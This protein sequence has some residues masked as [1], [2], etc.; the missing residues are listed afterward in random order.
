A[1]GGM[2]EVYLAEDVKLRRRVA[3]KILPEDMFADKSRLLRFEREADVVSALNHPNILTIFEF[4]WE[5]NI[6]L[7]ASEF[8][9]GETLRSRIGSSNLRLPETLDIAIQIASALHAAHQA[10]VVHRDI[11]PEN[12]MIRDDGYVKVLDFGLA[13]LTEGITSGSDDETR[14]ILSR[15]GV[16]MGTVTYMSPEQTRAK[17]IDAR[18]DLFSLGVVL[19]EMLAG[20]VPFKGETTTDV[21]AEIIQKNP[22]PVRRFM[23]DDAPAEL[24][25]IIGKTLEKN[26]E[27]RYQ[28]AADLLIDLKHLQKKLEITANIEAAATNVETINNHVTEASIDRP[29]TRGAAFTGTARKPWYAL[30]ALVALM[31]AAV[32]ALG[33]WYYNGLNP[34]QIDS[35]A[36]MPFVNESGNSD[37]EYLSDGM[38]ETLISS[39]SQL[40]NLNVK[41]RSSVFRY[42]GKDTDAQIIGKE[43]NVQAI[44]KGRVLQRGRDL[45]LYVEL[46]E[47]ATENS[48]WKQT[49]NKTLTNLVSL[50]SEIAQ[51]VADKLKVKLSG[52]DEQKL[53]KNYTENAEA[54]Q[55]YLKGRYHL[56][57][58]TRKEIE[59][60]G[61]Y[62]QQA[63]AIDPSYALAYA[64]LADANRTLAMAGERPPK[65]FMP[66]A[67]AAAAKAIE[68]DETLA[69][70]H[71]I[72][73]F[74]MYWY[75]RDWDSAEREIRRSIEL[76]PNNSDSRIYYAHLLSSTGRVSQSLSEARRS[77]ELEPLN[78]RNNALECQFLLAAGQ[79][80]EALIKAK[81]VIDLNPDH[82]LP[83]QQA[84][85]AYIEKGMYAEAVVESGKSIERNEFA[86]VPRA[87]L[88]YALARSGMRAEAETVLNELLRMRKEDYASPYSIAM[89]YYGLGNHDEAITWLENAVEA[90]DPRVV[91][92]TMDPKWKNFRGDTRFED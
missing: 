59:K 16:I 34:K 10:G 81:K 40:P 63:I 80:D 26:R 70:A 43:L 8:V 67:K 52:A 5:S 25:R 17:T 74:V 54:Y 11:K 91:F 15:P 7:L 60:G 45:I 42:K 44:L 12:I 47:A 1:S 58:T 4:G 36:V 27:E 73:G 68:L 56:L 29:T 83:H 41:A 22:P 64:G 71:G 46:V 84:A 89:V 49:Y 3:L 32:L 76:D 86:T 78:A 82:W 35:I 88:G 79:F 72:L 75:D 28:T 19:Y 30:A 38:T 21:I 92:L 18:S 66:M 90:R 62:F 50:Q 57:K 48:L 37:V 33:Y 2:G 65:E 24:D 20:R 14:R 51:D 23:D 85:A 6:H 61:S 13:K 87:F 55:F 53:A 69:E 39:L 31:L 9:K 77:S